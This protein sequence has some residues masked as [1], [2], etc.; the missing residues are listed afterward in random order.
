MNEK[1]M[2]G[3]GATAANGYQNGID[4]DNDGQRPEINDRLSDATHSQADFSQDRVI[5]ASKIA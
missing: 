1:E 3:P 2:Q 5:Y 4:D